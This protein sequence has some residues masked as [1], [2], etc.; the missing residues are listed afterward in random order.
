LRTDF[1]I[2]KIREINLF[3]PLKREDI[4]MANLKDGKLD[5]LTAENSVLI[6][7]DYQPTMIKSVAS[8][9]KTRIKSAVICAAKAASILKVPVVLSS[10]NPQYNG[11][12]FQKLLHYFKIRKYSHGKYRVSMHLKMRK[13]GTL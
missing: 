8:G 4:K 3:I 9:D 11:D 2:K 7:V 13:P 5:L 10:I 1:Q 6:L 12:V